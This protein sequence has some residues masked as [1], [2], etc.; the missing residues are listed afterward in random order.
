[1]KRKYEPGQDL[2]HQKTH[3][4]IGADNEMFP[5]CHSQKNISKI[6]YNYIKLIRTIK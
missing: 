4:K 1:M 2:L 5:K 3:S 6:Q